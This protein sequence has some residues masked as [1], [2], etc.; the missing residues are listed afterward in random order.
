MKYY[1]TVADGYIHAIEQRESPATS[2]EITEA[3]YNRIK[4]II[5]NRPTAPEGYGY[6]LTESLEWELYELPPA[7]EDT[8]LTAEEALEIIVG[9]T[10]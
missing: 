2:E 9:G 8:E 4:A 3:E 10:A 1:K 5:D 7:E 6:R